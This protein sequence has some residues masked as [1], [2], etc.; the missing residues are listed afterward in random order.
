MVGGVVADHEP[1]PRP[2]FTV[3]PRRWVI[4]G[5]VPWLGK[6]RRMSKDYGRLPE[7]SGAFVYVAITRLMMRRLAC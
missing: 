2:A 7:S 4:E 5:T 1:P 3:L 6:N